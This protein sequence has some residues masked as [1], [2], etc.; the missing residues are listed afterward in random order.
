MP[1]GRGGWKREPAFSPRGWECVRIPKKQE[2]RD[3]RGAPC[4]FE[5]DLRRAQTGSRVSAQAPSTS[6]NEIDVPSGIVSLE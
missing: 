6:D 3:A 2:P 5:T 1:G 4:A